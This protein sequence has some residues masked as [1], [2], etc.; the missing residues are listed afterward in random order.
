M[1]Y[2]VGKAFSSIC[3]CIRDCAVGLRL[4]MSRFLS[5][6]VC[7]SSLMLRDI[8]TAKITIMPTT[9]PTTNIQNDSIVMYFLFSIFVF[10]R[11]FKGKLLI[12]YNKI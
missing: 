3:D 9:R 12:L 8:T 7:P 4:C 11:K 1:L 6:L 10:V 2:G 5:A